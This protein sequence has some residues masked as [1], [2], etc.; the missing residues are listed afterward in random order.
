M[1]Q[2]LISI[3]S[4]L[5]LATFGQTYTIS[6]YVTDPANGENLIGVCVQAVGTNKGVTTNNYGFYSLSLPKGEYSIAVS[7]LGYQTIDTSIVLK[8]NV[9]Y[10]AGMHE[11]TQA[12]EEVVVTANSDREKV[13]KAS[14]GVE[15]LNMK[16]ISNLPVVFGENDVLKVVQLMPGVQPSSEGS[17][18]FNVRG[19]NYDQN[20]IL[21]D[22][23]VVYNPGHLFSFISVF[24]D[25]AINS[26]TLYK[27]TMPAEYG[28][29]TSSVLDISMKEGNN[30]S[31]SG[32]GSI[33]LI[34]SKFAFEGPIIKDK[35]SFLVSARR[36]T[37][38]LLT[39]PMINMHGGS[40]KQDDYYFYD[41][42]AKINYKF[43]D[44][45]RLFFSNYFGRDVFIFGTADKRFTFD[46]PGETSPLPYVGI[47]CFL[48][49]F[50]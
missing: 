38:D 21:L 39:K 46:I 37:I 16:S 40:M 29:R 28:G 24:N 18:G 4:F 9:I 42:N 47:T 17:S 43:S 2:I 34:A 31:Y 12:L 1:K 30:K 41:L 15:T 7:Y 44:K 33:G 19:G 6:G 27:G 35:C 32:K 3:F 22:E 50:S 11:Q 45:D 48:T 25:D 14:M 36:S 13:R 8:N 49:S 26:M 23:A 10:H 5:S 20:L